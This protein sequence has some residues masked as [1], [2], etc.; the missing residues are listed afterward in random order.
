MLPLGM[1]GAALGLLLV[2]AA[3]KGEHPFAPISRAFG[4]SDPPAPGASASALVGDTLTQVGETVG[5][6]VSA[7][8]DT[9][10]RVRAFKAAITDRFPGLRFAGE[11]ACR[12]IIP[13]D[14][15]AT[16]DEPWSQHAYNVGGGECNAVDYSGSDDEMRRATAWCNLNKVRFGIANVIPPGSAV[17]ALHVDFAPNRTGDPGCS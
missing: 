3:V 9:A 4:L 17:N 8:G 2:N 13:H 16:N 1:I 12:H 5:T 10:S 14:R 7:A 11:C 6:A 15:A